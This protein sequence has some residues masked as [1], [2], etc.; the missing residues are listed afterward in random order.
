MKGL[1]GA[2]SVRF[3]HLGTGFMEFVNIYQVHGMCTF[4]HE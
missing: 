4:L 1:L 2:I 3:L